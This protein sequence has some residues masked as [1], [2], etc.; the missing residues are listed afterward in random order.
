MMIKDPYL[1]A[2]EAYERL[3]REY[4]KHGSL[5]I[6]FDFDGTVHDYHKTGAIYPHVTQL[7]R[8][9]K[10]LN[11]QLICWSCYKDHDYIANYLKEHDIPYDGINTDGITL[12]WETRKPFFN[13]LL[14][15]RAGLRQV[16]WDLRNLVEK[17][18]SE[19]NDIQPT[20]DPVHG[21]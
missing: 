4:K 8:D 3:Y 10:G 7:L 13:A 1:R 21:C 6:G 18:K 11:C 14:D 17:I 19:A 16:F 5:T 9:L 15:D 2:E 12:P 20:G